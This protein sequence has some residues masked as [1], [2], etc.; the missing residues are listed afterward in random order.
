MTNKRTTTLR[1]DHDD[2]EAGLLW[3]P[4][5]NYTWDDECRDAA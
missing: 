2:L 4:E 1:N 5:P 3:P